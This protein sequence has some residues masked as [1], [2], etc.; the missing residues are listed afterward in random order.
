MTPY[1]LLFPGGAFLLLI[2]NALGFSIPGAAPPG[3]RSR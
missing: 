3:N 1:L 2:P